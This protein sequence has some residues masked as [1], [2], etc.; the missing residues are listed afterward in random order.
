MARILIREAVGLDVE[1]DRKLADFYGRVTDLIS[2]ALREGQEM[3]LVRAC[4]PDVIAWCILGSVKEVV[5]RLFVV[6]AP[7]KVH[8]QTGREMVSYILDGIFRR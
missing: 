3:G 7:D 8:V 6:G 2:R 4:D 1:F 5:D